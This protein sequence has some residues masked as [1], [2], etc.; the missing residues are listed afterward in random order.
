MT[1]KE[2]EQVLFCLKKIHQPNAFVNEAICSVERDIYRRE[3]QSK[4]QK[5]LG[6]DEYW[7]M[8][9]PG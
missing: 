2:L 9:S 5:D 6:K 8:N 3:Q 7:T 4:A 1:R